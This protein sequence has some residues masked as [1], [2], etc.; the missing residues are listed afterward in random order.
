MLTIETNFLFPQ[1]ILDEYGALLES[2]VFFDIETTGLHRR[3][4]HLYLIGTLT[5]Q[6]DHWLLTQWFAEKPSEEPLLL[7]SFLST[8]SPESHLIHYN[9]QSFD[10]PYLRAKCA[11]YQTSATPLTAC[12][13]LD[14]YRSIRPFQKYLDPG[15][16]TQKDAEHF[17]G[18][19]RNDP[20]TGG[21]LITCY[22]EY[23]NTVDPNLKKALLLHNQEDILNMPKLLPLTAYQQL[24]QVFASQDP[25]CTQKN[26][27]QLIAWNYHPDALTIQLQL[28]Y[29]LP[30][31]I[32]CETPYFHL[33]ASHKGATLTI[34]PYQ[35]TLRYYYPNPKD[36]YYLP[37]EN[38]AIHKSVGTYVEKAHRI[39]A[40][41]A[42]CY[43]TH[44]GVFLP[45]PI[46]L[47]S[48]A[49]KQNPK[50][51]ITYFNPDQ[52]ADENTISLRKQYIHLVLNT[53]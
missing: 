28:P 33:A 41:A 14:I 7:E 32:T 50:D 37:A 5:N 2:S 36:Y 30:A 44:T 11:F 49:L 39:Q 35:G 22:K 47:F 19:H 51:S 10:I 52:L 53:L 38:K 46:P 25:E 3:Y 31:P 42:T 6:S 23:L 16:L 24:N 4:S 26:N 20:Y 8:L 27:V 18:I 29:S 13:S 45:Q 15:S 34:L 12:T 21:E 1:N 40:T 9:G 48:P 43:H 17:L